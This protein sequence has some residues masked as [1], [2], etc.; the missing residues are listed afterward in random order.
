MVDREGKMVAESIDMRTQGQF[1][2]MLRE[3]GLK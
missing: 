2:E 1:L 3:A